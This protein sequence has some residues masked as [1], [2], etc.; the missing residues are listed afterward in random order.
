MKN[1]ERSRCSNEER[2]LDFNN[3]R[4]IFMLFYQEIYNVILLLS[5]I[6]I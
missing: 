4:F 3:G 1:D 6:N 5:L 2:C